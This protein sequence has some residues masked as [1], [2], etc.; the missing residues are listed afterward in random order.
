MLHY[1][2]HKGLF[3]MVDGL[4]RAGVP[5]EVKNN[6]GKTALDIAKDHLDITTRDGYEA[7][8]V[9]KNIVDRLELAASGETPESVLAKQDVAKMTSKDLRDAIEKVAAKDEKVKKE[10]EKCVEKE[11]LV[12][13]FKRLFQDK[14]K[15][16]FSALL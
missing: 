12:E 2:S 3:E 6:E 4:V 10:L 13:L 14:K 15:G 8:G 5:H 9:Y 11:H 16:W 1:A 7:A